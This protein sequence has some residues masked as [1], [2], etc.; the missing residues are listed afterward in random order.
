[1]VYV[2]TLRLKY[3]LQVDI[4]NF[5]LAEGSSYFPALLDWPW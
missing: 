5:F 1:V 4:S 3:V 2:S